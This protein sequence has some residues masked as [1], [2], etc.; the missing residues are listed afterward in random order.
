MKFLLDVCA[1]SGVLQETLDGLGHDALAVRAG[2]AASDRALLDLASRERRVVLTPDGTFGEFPSPLRQ[3][4]PCIV[5]F[6]GLGVAGE[7]AAI[8]DLIEHHAHEMQTGTIIVI[9]RNRVR[10]RPARNHRGG[11]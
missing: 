8:R 3:P 9:T 2:Y 5:R 7:A 6:E 11:R 1:A 10:I 4:L